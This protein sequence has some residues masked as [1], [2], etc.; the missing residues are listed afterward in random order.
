MFEVSSFG[1]NVIL[2]EDYV[3]VSREW[4]QKKVDVGWVCLQW[5]KEYGGCGVMLFEQII[6]MQEEGIYGMLLLFFIIG[7]GMCGLIFI[8]YVNEE[9]KREF[10]LFFVFGEKIWCQ[11]F[12]ELGVGF[13]FVG[14]CMCV[15]CDGDDWVVNGQK[16][17]ILGVQYFDW[18]ILVMCMDIDVF[19]YKG[20]I[21]FFFDMRS[22]GIEIW[23]IKQVVGELGF[24]EVFFSNVCIFDVQCFGDVG[25]GW[26]VLLIMLMNECL[27]IGSGMSIGFLVVFEFVEEYCGGEMMQDSFVCDCVVD[28]YVNEV[29]LCYIGYCVIIVLVCGEML[30]LENLIGKVVVGNMMQVVVDFVFDF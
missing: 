19:K 18:G 24:N 27:V 21:F 13:D 25:D 30:G 2:F 10:L 12:S 5:F 15:V 23:L 7:Y 26:F 9:Q 3:C 6:W 20:L 4:Q 8:V 22:L 14:I 16:V 11:L 17:W 29:G 1:C 28:W